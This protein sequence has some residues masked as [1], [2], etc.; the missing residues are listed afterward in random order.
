MSYLEIEPAR[1]KAKDPEQ[2]WDN[3]EWYAKR[4]HNGWRF[5]QHFGHELERNFMTGR[6]VSSVTGFLSEKGRC[7]PQL[8]IPHN[9][10]KY[11]VLDG[12]VTHAG[13]RDVAG[14]MNVEP[15]D[16][17][18]RIAEIGP[19]TYEVFDILFYDGEDLR[20]HSMFE[21]R[22]MLEKFFRDV[23]NPLV[24][25]GEQIKKD[26]R[27]YYDSIVASGGEGVV[28]KDVSAAYGDSGAWVKV[29]R[30]H[31]VDVVITGFT[32]A[33]EGKT[34]KYLGQIGAA[35]CSV[36]TSTG[37]LLEVAR[38]SGMD[39][40]TRLDMTKNA[41]SWIGKVVEIQAQEWGKDRL[42]HPRW[43]RVRDDV[44]AHDCTF[45]KMKF[46]LE[47]NAAATPTEEPRQGRLL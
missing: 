39:D 36:Y 38:V 34:A 32:D 27:A 47:R 7:C 14:I 10:L 2:L 22:M 31:L 35:L 24:K 4:K 45:V 17:Q 37:Q 13:L 41:A 42:M 6:R 43:S 25:L 23:R 12:E 29:K 16:A 26:K 46:E 40:A 30:Y 28:L 9:G 33:K 11:T 1:A 15:E 8:W 21:R 20:E 19:P 5:L 18:R 44:P 3:P